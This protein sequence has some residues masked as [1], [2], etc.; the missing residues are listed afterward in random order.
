MD[1]PYKPYK[2]NYF[3]KKNVKPS[4]SEV[5]NQ[6]V[7]KFLSSSVLSRF[8]QGKPQRQ[9]GGERMRLFRLLEINRSE[10]PFRIEAMSLKASFSSL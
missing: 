3:K 10:Y 6:Q 4:D 5:P 9:K 8:K 2:T 7:M 1:Y